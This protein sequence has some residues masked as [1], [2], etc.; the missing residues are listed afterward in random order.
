MLDYSIFYRRSIDVRRI[1][2]ELPT[3]DIFVSAFNSSERVGSVFA[4][5]PARKKIWL[6]HPEY[7]YTPM[8]EP[9]TG[10]KVHPSSSD[11][12]VQVDALL[13]EIGDLNGKS[14]CIDITGF[15]RHVL[16]FL[17][18][19]LERLRV[20]QFTA[21]YSEPVSYVKQEDTLFS[22]T[23]TG[24]V[25]PIRGMAG[26]NSSSGRDYLVIAVGYDHRLVSEVTNHKD[27]SS[28][29]PLFAFPSLSPDMYQ[30]SAIRASESGDVTLEREWISNRRFAPANDPFSTALVVS[31]IV[32]EIEKKGGDANIYLAP[33]STKVQ[34]LGFSIYWL[35]EG[36]SRGAVSMLLPE[37]ETYSRETS[38]GLKRLW[39]FTVELD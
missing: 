9:P 4:D 15:M 21:I 7:R 23:T 38:V 27:N 5:V 22:T 20:S 11:E 35:L 14:L 16:V 18:A 33:L 32:S 12:V 34:A 26:S 19:K 24:K 37:C 30:Q 13:A 17:V 2:K 29:Y 31:E 10:G 36:K 6:I 3:F 28:V 1:E 39:S 25:R 8:E